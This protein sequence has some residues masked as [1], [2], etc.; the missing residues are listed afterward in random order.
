VSA[1]S[2]PVVR[3]GYIS[4]V[5]G[6]TGWVK[7]HSFTEPRGNLIDYPDWLLEHRG[8]RRTVALEQAKV[9]AKNV[10]AKL[11]GI[12]DRDQAVELIGAE[13]SVPRA[14]LP[15]LGAGE[16]YWADLEGLAV[17]TR[18]GDVLGRVER[19]IATGA[20]DVLVLDGGPDRLIPFVPGRIVQHV[21]LDTG[22]IVVDWEASYWE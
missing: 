14:A 16:Y 19:L 10:L 15:P 18:A 8:Q 21:D 5:H 22:E 1:K 4:G 6:V 9:T 20:H 7:V 12:D 3:L 13:I 17:K 11:V 2:D